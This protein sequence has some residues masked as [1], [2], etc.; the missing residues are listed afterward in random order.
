MNTD[1]LSVDTEEEEEDITEEAQ[2]T[3]LAILIASPHNL[4]SALHRPI[5]SDAK[6]SLTSYYY[7]SSA[8][9]GKKGRFILGY[10]QRQV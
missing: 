8:T 3:E 4:P 10:E 5:L 9:S 1:W 6:L 2:C 7:F